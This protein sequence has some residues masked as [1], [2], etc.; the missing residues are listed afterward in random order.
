[1]NATSTDRLLA[2]AGVFQA[3]ALVD[4]LAHRGRSGVDE[5]ALKASIGSL[6]ETDPANVAAVYGGMDG[7]R[8]GLKSLIEH[9]GRRGMDPQHPIAYYVACS[10]FLE[11]RIHRSNTL[12]QRLTDG[13]STAIAKVPTF[14][15]DGER[16]LAHLAEV[17]QQTAG[18]AGPRIVVRGAP[19]QIKIAGAADLIRTLLLAAI[20][21]A[22]LW[23]QCGGRR[24]TLLL[25]SRRLRQEAGELLVRMNRDHS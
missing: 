13:I 2:L 21:S 8:L 15:T 4:Q 25:Q 5:T 20:R 19:E 18:E 24:L 17:Y 9:L 23:R 22:W 6:Y 10:M 1:M 7:V 12:V 16:T 14:G 3:V 11:G